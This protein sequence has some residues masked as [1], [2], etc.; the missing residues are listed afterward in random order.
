MSEEH[1]H[2]AVSRIVR[3][4]E[5]RGLLDALSVALSTSDLTA[6]MLEVMH[7]RAADLTAAQ[8][9]DQYE[10]DR[11]VRPSS[12]DPRRLLELESLALATLAPPF[13]PIA[14]SPLVPLGTHSV[15][16]GVHQ[17]RVVTTVRGSEVAADPTNSLALEAAVRRR[18]LLS[19]DVRS[20]VVVR[21]VAVDRV[22]RAQKFEGPG[23][24]A[25]F[26]LLGLASAGRDTGDHEFEAASM[27]HH[28]E[29]LIAICQASGHR[30]VHVRVSD[31]SGQHRELVAA[32]IETVH[33]DGV[34]IAAWP[35]RTAAR[36][37]Y[38]SLCVK[39]YVVDN[40]EEVEVA[41]GGLV[42]WTRSL[43]GSNKERLMISGLSLERLATLT[44]T[45]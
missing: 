23:A 12:V 14:T 43:V 11:F 25:H 5:G 1:L 3:E 10:R 40:D 39:L 35:E 37:Y 22:V 24:F 8:V 6:L 27:Q 29:A 19:G 36:G 21:L 42:D 9:L 20:S 33:T 15:V 4:Q 7:R 13:E 34:R 31:F 44:S 28:I 41:D 30:Q 38:P 18:A 26:S 45:R 17:N 32:L 16:A 2:P